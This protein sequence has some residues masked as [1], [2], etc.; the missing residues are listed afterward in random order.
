V[1]RYYF[2]YRC[3]GDDGPEYYLR[4][5]TEPVRPLAKLEFSAHT[6]AAS[7]TYWQNEDDEAL[8]RSGFGSARHQF[9]RKGVNG[10]VAPEALCEAQDC[11][12]PFEHPIHMRS[13]AN[14]WMSPKDPTRD[15][16]R[17][18]TLDGEANHGIRKPENMPFREFMYEGNLIREWLPHRSRVVRLDTERQHRLRLKMKPQKPPRSCPLPTMRKYTQITLDGMHRRTRY[19]QDTSIVT[20]MM[21]G[22]R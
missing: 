10:V 17:A 7:P 11:G 3:W 2:D 6:V 20:L 16:S 1:P 13:Q 22:D 4:P 8:E 18:A 19:I 15:E 21:A 12:M 5:S 9:I 14:E